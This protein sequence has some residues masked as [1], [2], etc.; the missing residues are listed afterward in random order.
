MNSDPGRVRPDGND[1]LREET[2]MED[3]RRQL[4]QASIFAGMSEGVMGIRFDGRIEI[5]NDAALEILGKTREELEGHSFAHC[6]FGEEINDGFTQSVLDAIYKKGQKL[7]SVVPYSTGSEIKQLRILSSYLVNNEERIG[8]VLVISDITELVE[9]RDAIKAMEKIQEL[10]RQLELRNRLLKETFGRYL[11]DD[12][13]EE[14]LESPDGW[15]LGGQKR[16]LTIL[17]S[18]LRGFTMLCERMEPQDLVTM[19]NHYFSEMY[20]EIQRYNGTLIEFLGDGMFVIFGAPIRTDHHAANAVAAALAMQ[21]RL[22]EVN[23]WNAERGYE[24][25]DMGIGINTDETILGNIGSTKRTK[26]GVIGAA[27]NLAGRIESFTTGGQVLISPTTAAAIEEELLVDFTFKASP[28]G[29]KEPIT[30]TCVRGI[31]KPYDIYIPKKTV[32][33]VPLERP[34]PVIFYSLEGKQV[35]D[36]M[37]KGSLLSVSETGAVLETDE[38]I[39]LY[40]NLRMEIGGDLYAKAVAL[41]GSKATL[42]FTAKPLD[43]DKWLKR[44]LSR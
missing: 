37:R 24:H 29:V 31:G 44:I 22:I 41:D 36:R 20:E 23:K 6:F 17:M 13:V 4:F 2:V 26:Y 8:I 27:V 39:S 25:L 16:V 40:D 15:K 32:E 9:L 19:L 11:S 10:N 35:D 12:I 1:V 30:I 5:V 42:V 43:F 38:K 3:E 7:H 21:K 18:D 34:E 28:K 14:I 33:M